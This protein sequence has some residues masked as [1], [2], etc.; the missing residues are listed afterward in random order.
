MPWQE[1]MKKKKTSFELVKKKLFDLFSFQKGIKDLD[2][3][4][5]CNLNESLPLLPQYNYEEEC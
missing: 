3:V 5:K 2:L 4:C 1:N